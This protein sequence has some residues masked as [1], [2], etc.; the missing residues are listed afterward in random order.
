MRISVID[1]HTGGEPTRVVIAGG[2]DLGGGSLAERRERFRTQFDWFRAAVVNE[3]RGSDVLVGAILLPPHDPRCDGRRDLLQQRRLLEHVRP[4]HDRAGRDPGRIWAASLR[5]STASKRRSA[6]SQPGW[7]SP[8]RSRSRM[9]PATG[10]RPT[11]RWRSRVYG[12]VHGDVAWGGN[13]FYLVH[14]H[15]LP[16]TLA[17]L[18]RLTDC[19][20][21]IRQALP[22]QGITGADG[23][24]IDHIELFGPPEHPAGRQQ[25][26]RPLPRPGLRPLALR[27]RHQRQAGLP[28]RGRQTQAGASLAAREHRRQH[29][30][31][32][33]RNP[34]GPRLSA[35]SR[36]G[37]HHQRSHARARSSRPVRP[38]H[39]C[40]PMCHS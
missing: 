3:P 34:R 32:F 38:W 7:M 21:K 39:S 33:G 10:T 2:P 13:W 1:S 29:F 11:F 30:R 40:D 27:H 28:G 16:V 26:L 15:G 35:D 9:S 12:R 37:L 18:E 6:S 24:E 23:E 36:L 4:R 14:D 19:A 31:G 8:A 5:A 20:W 17:N 25:E 22:R